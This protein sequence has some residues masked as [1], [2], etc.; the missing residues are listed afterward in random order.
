[1]IFLSMRLTLVLIV[2]LALAR[3]AAAEPAPLQMKGMALGLYFAEAD[4]KGWSFQNMLGE[5]RSIGADHVSLVVS[6][7]QPDV[8]SVTLAPDA[9]TTLPDARL[10]SLIRDAH[11]RGLKV[12]LFPI[13]E[14][15]V[16]R[17]LEWR[18]TIAPRDV[19][20]WWT[21]YQKF[22]LHYARIAAEEK[23]ELFSVGSELLSTE[24]WRDRWAALI[25]Q[26]RKGFRGKVLYS[27]NWD[28]YEKV[29]FW[30]LVD[31][32]GVTA[33]NELSRSH[34]ASE[35]EL[36]TAWR[37]VRA[38]LSAFSQKAGKPIIITEVGYTSQDGSAV[39][40]WDYTS[41]S[42]LDLEEQRRC[43]AAFVT[44]WNGEN[45]L[46]GVFWWNWFGAGGGKDTYYTP[47]GKPAEG[48]LRRWYGAGKSQSP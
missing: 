18:G 45:T 32:L 3:N 47:K 10:R 26:V 4:Y 43:Y 37:N 28:H 44:A 1:M 12:F 24:T 9:A 35:E 40:P 22:I 7:K 33:Y 34:D 39:H 2:S 27:A 48:I 31:Y 21:G 23:V 36:T 16:R 5:I 17:P 30:D 11:K 13:I 41:R 15:D 38:S 42:P 8:R 29:S 25:S 20:A 46:A 14:L 19:S 6:W